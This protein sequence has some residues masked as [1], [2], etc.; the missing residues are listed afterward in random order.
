MPGREASQEM[1]SCP[2]PLSK[3]ASNSIGYNLSGRQQAASFAL[4]EE[5]NAEKSVMA[6]ESVLRSRLFFVDLSTAAWAMLEWLRK[7]RR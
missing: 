1:V 6:C 3:I 2:F 5:G 7:L 4:S